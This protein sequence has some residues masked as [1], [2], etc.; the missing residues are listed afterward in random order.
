MSLL[1]TYLPGQKS[2]VW[3]GDHSFVKRY[4][5]DEPY[6]ERCTG[7][8]ETL[9]VKL[10]SWSGTLD[11]ILQASES[12]L[13]DVSNCCLVAPN[14]NCPNNKLTAGGAPEQMERIHRV[15]DKAKAE[16]G[17]QRVIVIGYSGGGFLTL[18]FLAT[19]PAYVDGFVAWL[20]INN[21]TQWHAE[22][23]AMGGGECPQIEACM[24]GTPPQVPAIYTDRSPAS[25]LGSVTGK[26]GYIRTGANDTTTQPHHGYD[27]Y[28]LLAANN[29]VDY[30][31]IPNWGHDFDDGEAVNQ[32]NALIAAL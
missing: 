23:A 1:T 20:P 14:A 7:I 17:C 16:H 27:A 24:G 2:E 25:R 6:W 28:Q 8:P 31:Q 26:R 12:A 11:Q 4:A 5:G 15:I 9:I 29:V 10:P 19:N 22:N 3:I 13:R 30:L 32:I 18:Q 21:M